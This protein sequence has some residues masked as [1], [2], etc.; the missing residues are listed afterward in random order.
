MEGLD[1][2][3]AVREELYIFWPPARLKFPILVQPEEFNN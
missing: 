2:K 3:L 1:Q